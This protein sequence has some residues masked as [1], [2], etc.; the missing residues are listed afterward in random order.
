MRDSHHVLEKSDNHWSCFVYYLSTDYHHMKG[1]TQ[2]FGIV[3]IFSIL[4]DIHVYKLE[5]L[6]EFVQGP[7][8]YG[9]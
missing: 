4:N 5:Q 1:E 6:G 3:Y 8:Q 7:V 2:I 9:G